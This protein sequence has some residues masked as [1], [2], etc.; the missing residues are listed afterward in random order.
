MCTDAEECVQCKFGMLC[1]GSDLIIKLMW[2]LL[3]EY[4]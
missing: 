3:V 4:Y 2:M 1:A